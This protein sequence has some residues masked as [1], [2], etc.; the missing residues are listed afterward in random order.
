MSLARADI[1]ILV[2]D[3][4]TV[5]A[6]N[7]LGFICSINISFSLSWFPACNNNSAKAF[8][9]VIIAA[10]FWTGKYAPCRRI[11][12]KTSEVTQ[13]VN[14]SA[15]GFLLWKIT[16]YKLLSLIK[17]ACWRLP[18]ESM[19]SLVMTPS[20]FN[21]ALSCDGLPISKISHTSFRWKYGWFSIWIVLTC[22]LLKLNICNSIRYPLF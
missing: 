21:L 11:A 6:N 2:S 16:L 8:L 19:T 13:S 5:S 10:A 4:S 1:K 7:A 9:S 18:S 20:S 14:S 15:S 17:F 3:A 12:G 22:W